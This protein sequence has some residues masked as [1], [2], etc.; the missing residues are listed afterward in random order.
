M[1][2]EA[3]PSLLSATGQFLT[4]GLAWPRVFRGPIPCFPQKPDHASVPFGGAGR[5][6][7]SLQAKPDLCDRAY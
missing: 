2:F 5:V 3:V 7:L 4:G 1:G 6:A